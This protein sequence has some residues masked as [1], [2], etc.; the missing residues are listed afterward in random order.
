MLLQAKVFTRPTAMDQIITL[1]LPA[2]LD[3]LGTTEA[4]FVRYRSQNETDHLRIRV[5]AGGHALQTV[6]AWTE[7]LTADHLASH[8]VI[9]GYRPEIGRYGTGSAGCR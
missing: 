9:D 1:R 3:E 6:A 5:P 4:W 2:L 7:Q 8:L